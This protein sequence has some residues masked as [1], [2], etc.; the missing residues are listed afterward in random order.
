MQE[1]WWQEKVYYAHGFGDLGNPGVADPISKY[2]PEGDSKEKGSN[3]MMLRG[4]VATVANLQ[5]FIPFP[6]AES[7]FNAADAQF[8]FPHPPFIRRKRGCG[9]KKKKTRKNLWGSFFFR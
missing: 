4:A 5:P 8:Y 7:W 6:Y 3:A 1:D 9:A 2:V